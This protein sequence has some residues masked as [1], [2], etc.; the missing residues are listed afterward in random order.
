MEI[1]EKFLIRR[2]SIIYFEISDYI[3]KILDLV[4]TIRT[5]T[6]TLK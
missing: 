1:Q 6:I 5:A 3:S 2:V 4:L